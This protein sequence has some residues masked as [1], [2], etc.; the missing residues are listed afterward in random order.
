MSPKVITVTLNPAIDKIMTTDEFIVG[1]LNR[2]R[3]LQTDP[4]GKGIN[5]SK[6]L[7]SYG[8]DQVALGILAG[9]N[10]KC[11]LDMLKEYPF[12][13]DFVMAPGETRVNM[14]IRDSK[15]GLI[16]EVNETGTTV[17]NED[18]KLFFE[19]LKKYLPSSEITIFAGSIPLDITDCFYASAIQLCARQKNRVIIDADGQAL[20]IA[21]QS[22]PYA[23]KPNHAEL[24]RLTGKVLDTYDKIRI[25]IER[26]VET[27]I[28]V[29]LVSMGERGAVFHSH[30]KTWNVSPL[31]V[32]VKSAVGAGDAMV[33]ALSWCMLK[34]ISPEDT[35]RITMAA[36]CLTAA[37]EGS[38][39]AEWQNIHKVYEKVVLRE[40]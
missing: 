14:K 16:T 18:I 21:V 22:K 31:Q 35:A 27:G 32:D 25:E 24:E 38:K 29:V 23:I 30:G 6:A 8:V 36:G 19:K 7:V 20:K 12:K 40:F 3:T 11:L 13:K 39:V 9:K 17:R 33:A 1:Q 26:L 37:E 2:V 28:Q 15:T 5:V 34:E 4:G 10:G